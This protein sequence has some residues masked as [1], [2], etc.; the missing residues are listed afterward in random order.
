MLA[1]SKEFSRISPAGK[2]E[3]RRACTLWLL[4]RRVGGFG[5]VNGPCLPP[6]RLPDLRRSY[7]GLSAPSIGKNDYEEHWLG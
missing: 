1:R 4:T 7:G 6:I 5:L 2:G 3:F